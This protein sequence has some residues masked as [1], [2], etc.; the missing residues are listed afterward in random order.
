MDPTS[1]LIMNF[2][3]ALYDDL[4]YIED[5]KRGKYFSTKLEYSLTDQGFLISRENISPQI[6]KKKRKFFFEPFKKYYCKKIEEWA[7][8]SYIPHIALFCDT[9]VSEERHQN[10]IQKL[11]FSIIEQLGKT[12]WLL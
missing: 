12:F 8:R 2:F 9:F 10:L 4:S 1:I 6:S 3:W 11:D 5:T 7:K